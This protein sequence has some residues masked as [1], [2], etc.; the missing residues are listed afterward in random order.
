MYYTFSG[1]AYTIDTDE[2]RLPRIEKH[3][4]NPDL[5]PYQEDNTH[6][7]LMGFKNS[8]VYDSLE[9]KAKLMSKDLTHPIHFPGSDLKSSYSEEI[10]L[11]AESMLKQY[12]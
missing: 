7:N 9:K 1:D 8:T 12:E 5:I 10:I 6:S 2:G 11:L 3:R 4:E